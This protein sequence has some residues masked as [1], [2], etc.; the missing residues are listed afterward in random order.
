MPYFTTEYTQNQ[1]KYASF[2]IAQTPRDA[3]LTAQMRG[4]G[5]KITGECRPAATRTTWKH[6]KNDISAGAAKRRLHYLTFLAFVA[7]KSKLLSVNNVMGDQGWF[8]EYVHR[9][10]SKAEPLNIPRKALD[11]EIF[12]TEALLGFIKWED[13]PKARKDSQA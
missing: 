12:R 10:A 2:L 4:L 5:E 8:H 6:H 11:R 1:N 3:L 9:K 13:Q 7:M